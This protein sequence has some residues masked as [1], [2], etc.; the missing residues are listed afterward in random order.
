M[1]LAE[2]ESK[3]QLKIGGSTY[4]LKKLRR[5]RP[6]G[7]TDRNKQ[8]ARSLLDSGPVWSQMKTTDASFLADLA[9]EWRD[10]AIWQEILEK[11]NSR[12]SAPGLTPDTLLRAL[13]VFTFDRTKTLS[14]YHCTR[15]SFT[16]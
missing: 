16:I 1:S 10:F 11:C 8:M 7:P 15:S 2:E 5:W 3:I 6:E 4:A 14:V 9:L 12:R 13:S